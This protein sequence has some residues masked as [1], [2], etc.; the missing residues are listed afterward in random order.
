MKNV[1]K[2]L[3]FMIYTII[4]FFVKDFKLLSF[5]F[6]LD[7][8]LAILLKLTLKNI[9]HNFKVFLPFILFT[10]VINI[11]FSSIYEGLLIGYRIIICYASTYIFSK[12]ISVLE[13]SMTIQ[14]LCFPLNL[15][16]VN[17]N[18]I[19]IIISVSICMIP[20]LKN[21][22]T[23]QIKAMKSK[24]KPLTIRNFINII[25]PLLI[26]ILKRT[27]EIEKTLISK[28]YDI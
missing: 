24:G 2:I 17:T 9:L 12:S 14:K 1:L 28:A 15:F 26:S 10:I 22:I 27:N 6:L 13:I 5:M 19:Y 16:G 4:I 25:Q 18:N 7:F 3:I 23:T 20:V 8:I 21:E 11:L